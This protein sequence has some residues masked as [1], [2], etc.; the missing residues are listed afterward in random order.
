MM[1]FR[2]MHDSIPCHGYNKKSHAYNAT[3]K[4]D[5]LGQY[6]TKHNLM[7]GIASCFMQ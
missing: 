7:S 4:N 2:V 5:K 1:L 3:Y 6:E